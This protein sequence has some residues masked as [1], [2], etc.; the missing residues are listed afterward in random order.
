MVVANVQCTVLPSEY[1]PAS[2]IACETGKALIKN[3][4]G[5]IVVR[6]RSDDT[7]YVAVSKQ[8]FIYVEPVVHSVAPK[9]GPQSGGTDVTLS[10]QDLDA[11]TDVNVAFGNIPCQVG[12]ISV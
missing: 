6:L 1:E 11:G 12:H 5:P 2:E 7:N 9:T 8:D 10:G 4:K 3:S